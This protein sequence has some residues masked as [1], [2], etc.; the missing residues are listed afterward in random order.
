MDSCLETAWI[1]KCFVVQQL[2]YGD[3]DLL[4]MASPQILGQRI[5]VLMEKKKETFLNQPP[6]DPHEAVLQLEERPE[7]LKGKLL[8]CVGPIVNGDTNWMYYWVYI[9]GQP[10]ST[11][12]YCREMLTG[13]QLPKHCNNQALPEYCNNQAAFCICPEWNCC[14]NTFYGWPIQ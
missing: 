10:L 8:N 7:Q 3:L 5:A 9:V 6:K 4:R 12:M 13:L 11:T 14:P 1:L 2:S